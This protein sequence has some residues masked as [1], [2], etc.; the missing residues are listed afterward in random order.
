MSEPLRHLLEHRELTKLLINHFGL[1][2]GYWVIALELGFGATMAAPVGEE[3]MPTGMTSI[4]KIG[5]QESQKESP[6]SVNA[7]EVNPLPKVA[8]KRTTKQK[9]K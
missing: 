6:L 3:P 8:R 7:A 9:A 4:R 5:I 2:E 1:H